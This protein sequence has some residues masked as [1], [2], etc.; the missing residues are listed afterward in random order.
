VLLIALIVATVFASPMT[1]GNKNDP[2]ATIKIDADPEYVLKQLLDQYKHFPDETQNKI[3]KLAQKFNE[4]DKETQEAALEETKKEKKSLLK[5]AAI[6][7]SGML[8]A[9][10]ALYMGM[11]AAKVDVPT[12]LN[13]CY[14]N[15]CILANKGQNRVQK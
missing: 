7:T 9:A 11:I 8:V 1:F 2:P 14:K 10:A 6:G 12:L 13:N 4:L 5:K 3:K 15:V